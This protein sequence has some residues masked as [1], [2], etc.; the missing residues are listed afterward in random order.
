MLDNPRHERFAQE[1]AKGNSATAAY[2][3]AGY[4]PDRPNALRLT[5]NDGVAKRVQELQAKGAARAEITIQGHIEELHRL[6][7]AAETGDKPAIGAAVRAEE[8]IG[9]VSGFYVEKQEHVYQQSAE[10]VLA[11]MDDVGPVGMTVIRHILEG[12]PA[13]D[14]TIMNLIHSITADINH[15]RN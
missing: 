11:T 4:T 7:K 9:K 6:A 1:L 14:E 15:V 2:E 13:D 12:L 8:L 5:T 3:L 10:Q